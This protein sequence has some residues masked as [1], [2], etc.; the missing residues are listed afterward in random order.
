MKEIIG[1]VV[2]FAALV[3]ALIF[4]ANWN[5]SVIIGLILVSIVTIIL[6]VDLI[7]KEIRKRKDDILP[8]TKYTYYTK[9]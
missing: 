1:I 2:A 7:K 9:G 5:G 6:L 4:V 3:I 8:D